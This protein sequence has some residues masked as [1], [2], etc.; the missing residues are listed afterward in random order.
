MLRIL[1]TRKESYEI[2]KIRRAKKI[3]TADLLK[4]LDI[5]TN[6]WVR[7]KSGDASM[8]FA[9]FQKLEELLGTSFNS[10]GK[11]FES[12]YNGSNNKKRLD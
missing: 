7:W 9:M 8:P 5:K 12:N 10:F 6:T 2:D 4:E 11:R 1:L 3:K